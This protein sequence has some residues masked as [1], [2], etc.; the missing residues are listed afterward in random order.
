MRKITII[1]T[2]LLILFLSACQ[3]DYHTRLNKGT[4]IISMNE[5]HVDAGCDLLSS[6]DEVISIPVINTDLDTTTIGS[7][8]IIYQLTKGKETYTCTRNIEVIDNTAPL[9]TL[10][11]GIDTVKQHEEHIDQGIIT[12]EDQSTL[13]ILITNNVDTTIIG[14]Y[15]ITYE[16]SDASGNTT[17][18]TRTVH[19]IE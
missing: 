2:L 19:V 17:F 9:V 14:S 5:T 4:D 6:N 7:Y 16:I 13:N 8:T 12:D 11:P 3:A 10:A 18:L 1:S 15:T